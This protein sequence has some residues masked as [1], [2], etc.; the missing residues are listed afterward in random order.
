M[1]R[2]TSKM[3]ALMLSTAMM[4]APAFAENQLLDS[5]FWW[6]DPEARVEKS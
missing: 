4:S 6:P 5:N 1:F 2:F 3:A